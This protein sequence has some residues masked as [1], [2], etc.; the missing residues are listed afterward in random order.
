MSATTI[1]RPA[2]ADLSD[3]RPRRRRRLRVLGLVL[4]IL[5]LAGA[6]WLVWFSSV[7][8]VKDV[9]VIGVDDDRA[10]AVLQTATVPRG[11][12]LASVDTETAR[13]A[14]LGLDW[15]ESADVRRGW[16]TEIVIAVTARV[17][18][19]VLAG[20]S[21]NERSAVDATGRV[22]S[23]EGAWAKGLPTVRAKDVGLPAAMS[24]LS[25]LP[26]NLVRRV[27]SLYATTRDD[28]SLTLRSGD[29]VRW[30][31]AD[32]AEFK[33]RVLKAIM[34]RKADV[35]DVSAPELPTTFRAR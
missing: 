4:A 27:V 18:I 24:V 7:L 2:T 22:F 35:Y 31:S 13:Q 6:A 33:A 10:Q 30:G 26:D 19:A 20:G 29:V 14:V 28:V 1:E 17:P 16:P 34:K 12:P 21:G 9:R 15:V 23:P 5:L 25:T 8:S 3:R 11:V 32:Q